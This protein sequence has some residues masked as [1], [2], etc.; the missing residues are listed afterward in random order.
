MALEVEVKFLVQD[1]AGVRERLLTAGAVLK[2]ARVFERNVRYDTE[3]EALLGRWELLRLRQDTAVKLTFKGPPP[4]AIQ[5]EAK[6]REELEVEVSDFDTAA[7]IV[8]RLGFVPKQIYEKYRETF[9]LG[10]VEVVLDEMPYGDFVELE[11]PE[12]DLKPLTAVLQLDWSKRILG[13]YLLLMAQLKAF[14][15]LPFNDLAFTHFAEKDF[16]IADLP[17]YDFGDI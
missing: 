14:H 6:V 15:N 1:L 11:G 13:N 3:D 8:Q 10:A 2:K 17:L 16:A 12:A 5:S 7:A 9:Q 4:Q